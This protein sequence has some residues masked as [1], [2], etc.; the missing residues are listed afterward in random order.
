[1]S[2]ISISTGIFMIKPG[3]IQTKRGTRAESKLMM[4]PPC[5]NLAAGRHDDEWVAI[6]GG[7][8]ETY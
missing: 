2:I 4:S 3:R 7:S 5:L 1:M 8:D 6:S